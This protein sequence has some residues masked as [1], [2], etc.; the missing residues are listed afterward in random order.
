[1]K[2][3]LLLLLLLLLVALTDALLLMPAG[4]AVTDGIILEA[5]LGMFTA[6]DRPPA[7][8]CRPIILCS[9]AFA[10]DV[11]RFYIEHLI[12]SQCDPNNVYSTSLAALVSTTVVTA[13]LATV[14]GDVP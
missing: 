8:C 11:G 4:L 13:V 5:V 6:A 1:M 7:A 3:T 2:Y 10:D 9:P 14:G 12:K